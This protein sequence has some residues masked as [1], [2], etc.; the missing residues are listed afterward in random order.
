MEAALAELGERGY[1]EICLASVLGRCGVSTGQFAS[2]FS[3][4][5][6]C[7]FAAYDAMTAA[8]VEEV[9]QR[10]ESEA[11]W[12]GRV[13]EGLRALIATL[14]ESPQLTSVLIRGFPSIRPAAYERYTAFLSELAALM[15]GGRECAEIGEELPDEVELLAVGAGE[16]LIFAE[17]EAGRLAALAEMVPEIL[18][19]VLVPLIGPG[20]AGEEMRSA[21]AAV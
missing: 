12:P 11:D 3:D 5:D 4:L 8:L 7:L 21:M 18:F 2:A 16:S 10:S 1:E 14:V 6:Q 15:G 20:R 9:R 17:I 19:S 13:R